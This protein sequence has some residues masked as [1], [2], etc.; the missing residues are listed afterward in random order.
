ML[1]AFSY[2]EQAAHLSLQTSQP[3]AGEQPGHESRAA[4]T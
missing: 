1:L 2:L 4:A 3:H